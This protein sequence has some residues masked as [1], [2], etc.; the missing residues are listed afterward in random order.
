MQHLAVRSDRQP[1]AFAGDKYFHQLDVP[2]TACNGVTYQLWSPHLETEP[3]TVQAQGEWLNG[4][5]P[6]VCP[7]HLDN[8][9]TPDRP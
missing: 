9:L 8:F 4:Y 2:C 5:L 1:P 7:R 3:E 6:T